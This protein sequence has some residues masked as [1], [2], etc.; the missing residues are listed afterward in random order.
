MENYLKLEQEIEQVY[1]I[2]N[3]ISLLQWD[4]AVNMPVGAVESREQEMTTLSLIVQRKLKSDKI[5]DLLKAAKEESSQLNQWQLANLREIDRRVENALCIDDDLQARFIAAT[6]Q[7]ELVWREARAANDYVQ[8]K[9]YLQTVLNCVREI[10][11]VK[12]QRFHCSLYDALV[13]EYDPERKSSEIKEIFT[14][15]KKKLPNLIQNIM[16]RQQSQ[17]VVPLTSKVSIAQQKSIAKK[18]MQVM[19][20]DL[21]HGR[22]DLSTHP[23]C[24]G[25]PYDVRL[26]NR[27]NEANFLSGIMGLIHETGHGLYEQNLPVGYKNQPVGRAKGMAI[28]ESQSLFMEVQVARTREFLEFLA[29]LLRDEFSFQGEEYSAENLYK[30]V[31]QVKYN[32]IRVEADEVTYPMHVILRFELEEALINNDLTLDEL[33]ECWNQKMQAYI[34][35]MPTTDQ[36][37]CLQDIHWPMGSF[38]YFPAYVNGAIIASMLMHRIKQCYPKIDREIRQGDFTTINQFLNQNIR[39]LGSLQETYRLIAAATGEEKINPEIFLN[40]LEEKYLA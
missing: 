28:H 22:L 2:D 7:C 23:F 5:T 15:L 13:D 14:I 32:F 4:I 38:G 30:L 3:V 29:K 36:Q 6:T 8:L 11:S 19:A 35:V 18:L 16:D 10:A 34:S 40:Y 21:N 25:T 24:N 31:N 20:F 39:N 17:S 9:P 26:T 1:Q 12:S 37:G 33:P 27:Y